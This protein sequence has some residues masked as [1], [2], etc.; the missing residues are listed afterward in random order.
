LSQSGSSS[1]S[2]DS[3]GDIDDDALEQGGNPFDGA[4][5]EPSVSLSA[6]LAVL[7]MWFK[8]NSTINLLS[9]IAIS[10]SS[11]LIWYSG[12]RSE[13]CY[14]T[15]S[16][17]LGGF[18]VASSTVALTMLTEYLIKCRVGYENVTEISSPRLMF[19]CCCVGVKSIAVVAFLLWS[20]VGI[21]YIAEARSNDDCTFTTGVLWMFTMHMIFVLM[22]CCVA[23]ITVCTAIRA[24]RRRRLPRV[25]PII[26]IKAE[27]YVEG[28]FA[29]N[30]D[31][32]CAICLD[33]YVRGVMVQRLP[34]DHYFHSSCISAWIE[35][36]DLCPLCKVSFVERPEGGDAADAHG[37]NN[38]AAAAVAGGAGAAGAGAAG[39]AAV[40]AAGDD[41]DDYTDDSSY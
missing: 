3:D 18:C 24:A 27:A 14:A 28:L 41:N 37:A 8:S 21:I 12:N 15:Q 17:F 25:R 10:V 13:P 7:Y 30:D 16:M 23:S 26:P 2:D 29:D 40:A 31:A 1:D 36:S 5:H 39:A 9:A 6:V 20:L 4:D 33:P 34:C 35:R 11:A 19:A 32:Q 22:C 38:A